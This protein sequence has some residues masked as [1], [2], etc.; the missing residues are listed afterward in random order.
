MTLATSSRRAVVV[1][2]GL[3]GGSV[4]LGLKAQGFFVSGIDA[5]RELEQSALEQGVIDAVGDDLTAE[6][7][8]VCVPAQHVVGVVDEIVAVPGRRVDVVIT[9]VCGVKAPLSFAISDDRFIGGH[10]MAGSEQLGLSGARGDLFIGATWVLCPTPRTEPSRYAALSS[11]VTSLGALPLALEA[12]DHDRLVAVVSHVPHLLAATLMR[13]AVIGAASDGALLQLAAGGFRD[14]TRV[15]AGDPEIWPDLC[16][17]NAVAIAATLEAVIT[18][19]TSVREMVLEGNR[20][21]LFDFLTLSS[22]ASRAL[23]AKQEVPTELV[24]LKVVVSDQPGTLAEVTTIASDLQVNVVDLQ[25][26]HSIEGGRGVLQLTIGKVGST[27]LSEALTKRGYH[28]F[29]EELR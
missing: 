17:T 16:A 14:M 6:F 3:I 4:A 8:F 24:M 29:V 28:C 11:L 1:G 2:V 26:A 21:G 7:V 5:R 27:A 23:P 13:R 10:P 20:T 12:N 19:L 22:Q 18:D 25:I 9:D 15:A